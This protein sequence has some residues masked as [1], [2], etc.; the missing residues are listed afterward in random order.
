MPQRAVDS[1]IHHSA[2]RQAPTDPAELNAAFALFNEL[3]D[4]LS[5]TYRAMEV[6]VGQLNEE[7]RRVSEARLRELEE[8]ERI[9]E[10][11][12]SLLSLLPAGVVVL[13]HA[14]R[15]S[16]CN[17][18]ARALLGEPLQG[19]RWRDVIARAFSPR[20]DDGHELSLASGRRVNL[21]TRSLEE[22]QGQLLLLTDLTETRDLQQ[23]LSRHQRLSEMGRML[24]SLAHQIRTPL[25]AAML[26]AGHLSER[27]LA[28]AQ[29]R[30]FAGKILSRLTHLEQQV[31]DMLVFAKGDLRLTD[32]L[33]VDALLDALRQAMEVPVA[34]AAAEV[35]FE[36]QCPDAQLHCNRDSM[37]GALMNLVMNAIQAATPAPGVQVSV[38]RKDDELCF[39]V[40]D[41]GPGIA[42]ELLARLEEPF[43]TTKPQGTGLG[44]SVVR[45]VARAHGGHFSLR[46][47]PGAGS[48]AS[49]YLPVWGVES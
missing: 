27:E 20:H 12:Q 15:V 28:P 22:G 32:T 19:A 10:R 7:L 23:R 11:L 29:T 47:T 35:S 2:G 41:N 34:A 45:A 30:R 36:V 1:H 14:G 25:S 24:S 16:D 4:Q 46:S 33:R 6:R 43:V 37:V 44:L 42:P 9:G 40:T 39:A 49:V 5:E 8:K 48:C 3:S 13:D 38:T 17:P 31:R 26:Y 18:A 21:A